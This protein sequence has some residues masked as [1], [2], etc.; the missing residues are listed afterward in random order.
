MIPCN[1]SSGRE[2]TEVVQCSTTMSR[3]VTGKMMRFSFIEP[4]LSEIKSLIVHLFIGG[5]V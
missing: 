5:T 4:S 1:L 2:V 3:N